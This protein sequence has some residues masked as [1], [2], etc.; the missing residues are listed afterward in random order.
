MLTA[1][2]KKTAVAQKELAELRESVFGNGGAKE[3]LEENALVDR[4]EALEI[5][6]MELKVG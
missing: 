4:N 5:E 2:K 1:A 6:N 3:I